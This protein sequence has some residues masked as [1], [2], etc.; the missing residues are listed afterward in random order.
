MLA[1]IAV[2]L[3]LMEIEWQSHVIDLT[4]NEW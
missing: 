3:N 1:K 4:K 2:Y